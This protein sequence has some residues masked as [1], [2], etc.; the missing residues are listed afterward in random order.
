M[1]IILAAFASGV[2]AQ[3][4]RLKPLFS[5]TGDD[6]FGKLN[7]P[8]D[9]FV[10]DEHGEIYVVDS[11]NRRVVVF[12]M[13]GFY[14]YQFA[15]P[16]GSGEPTGLVVNNRG[17]ILIAVGGKIAVCDFRGS[18]LEYVDFRNFPDAGKVKARRLAVDK[19]GNYYALDIAGR[20]VLAFD[21]DWEFRFVIDRESFPKVVRSLAHEKESKLSI[22]QPLNIGDIC[23]DDGG[24][25][26]MVDSMA[27]YVYVFN[28]KAEYV[29]S[30]GEPGAIFETLSLPFGVAIENQDKVLVT[31]STGHG[32]LGYDK[33]GNLL[34]AL[35]G[36]GEKEGRF[37]FPRYVSTDR[38][39]RIYI[40]EPFL[41]RIQILTIEY[42]SVEADQLSSSDRDA[43]G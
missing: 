16:A 9:V 19:K 10:D 7:M 8:G 22:V 20:R 43:T 39:G 41:G 17:E 28:N 26:Y 21:S 35:G 14:R 34:F 30:I 25:I 1:A 36:L 3:S 11:G 5:I 23:V 27:S 6:S 32:L 12:D 31:D 15:V 38:N 2:W 13:D 24:M 18:L 29:H 42:R 37:Y 33:K 4:Y 40:I